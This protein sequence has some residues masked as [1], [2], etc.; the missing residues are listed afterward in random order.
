VIAKFHVNFVNSGH[1]PRNRLAA[2]NALPGDTSISD[3]FSGL[4]DEPP[5][6][7]HSSCAILLRFDI[8]GIWLDYCVYII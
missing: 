6:D 4:C 8:F 3:P 5:S 2:K 7:V 1:L